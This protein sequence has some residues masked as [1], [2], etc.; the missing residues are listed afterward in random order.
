M[1]FELSRALQINILYNL[2]GLTFMYILVNGLLPTVLDL[3][4][5]SHKER[6]WYSELRTEVISMYSFGD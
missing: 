3:M 1:N 2:H 4:T 6:E 5:F